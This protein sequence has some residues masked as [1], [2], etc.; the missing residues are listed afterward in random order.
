[1]KIL[2]LSAA[3][4]LAA[5]ISAKD[6]N[7]DLKLGY[8]QSS[9]GLKDLSLGVKLGFVSDSWHNL[10]VGATI[11]SS[12]AL[13]KKDGAEIPFFNSSNNSY[14]IMCEAYLKGSWNNTEIKI[15]RQILDT[16]FADS[17]DIGMVP[18]SF[19]AVT[20]QNSSLPHTLFTFAYLYKMA[21]VDA[22][23]LEKFTKINGSKGVWTAGVSYSGIKN[24]QLSL[25]YY[26]INRA[27][28][29]KLA[30]IEA[31]YENSFGI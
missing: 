18:N 12:T 31:V 2:K 4:F 28:R 16:P 30:Y 14:A 17:D 10:S 20:V 26:N 5:T 7:G 29:D 23:I 6:F 24:L 25:W 22:E 11:C 9:K 1:M 19:E 3:A 8:K 13:N 27:S 15:G 21:G